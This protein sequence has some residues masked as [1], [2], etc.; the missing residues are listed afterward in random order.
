MENILIN[1]TSLVIQCYDF[2]LNEFIDHKMKFGEKININ[3]LSKKLNISQTP[4]REALN[5]LETFM[6]KNLQLY[7]EHGS[8]PNYD[9]TSKLSP[10]LHFGQ[11][12]PAYIY[13][14]IKWNDIK[15]EDFL[16]QL[17]VRRELSFNYVYYN[18]NYD[19]KLTEILPDWAIE[20]LA[21]HRSDKREYI[22][23]RE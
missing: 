10:Y 3:L 19:K 14:R 4:I 18:N 6:E 20:T 23:S 15:A 16:E 11:I 12:S 13:K 1:K 9:V 8:N 7:E 21:E 22:Y 5:R 17:I 2:I